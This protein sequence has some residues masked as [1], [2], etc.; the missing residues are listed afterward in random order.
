MTMRQV[1]QDFIDFC[2]EPP[3]AELRDVHVL[4]FHLDPLVDGPDVFPYNG[5][6][7]IRRSGGANRFFLDGYGIANAVIRHPTPL[8]LPT[9]VHIGF[10][11]DRPNPIEGGLEFG[12]GNDLGGFYPTPHRAG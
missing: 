12:E 9:M 7:L 2:L 4:A 10:Q 6:A 5:T 8:D 3:P 11:I 1:F